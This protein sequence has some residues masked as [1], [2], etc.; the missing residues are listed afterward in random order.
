MPLHD[1]LKHARQR[2]ALSGTQVHE[3]TGIGESSLSEFENGKREP[4]LSQMQKLADLY[5]APF[6]SSST[7]VR[8]RLSQR[9]FAY[10]PPQNAEEIEVGFLRHCERYYNLEVWCDER[11]AVSLP[12]ASGIPVASVTTRLKNLPS[13]CSGNCPWV[14]G[15][16][17]PVGSLGRGLRGQGIPSQI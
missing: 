8:L 9:C 10:G 6:R 3:R 17:V 13:E 11:A 16:C 7:M 14:I 12:P 5:R 2:A 15:R 4:S 1:R